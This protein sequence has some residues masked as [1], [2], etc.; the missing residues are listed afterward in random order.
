MPILD[1]SFEEAIAEKK[2]NRWSKWGY[3][4]KTDF[5]D[6]NGE[7]AGQRLWAS[8]I[9]TPKATH[10]KKY[11]RDA[12]FFAVG[13]CFAREIEKALSK[14]GL[15]FISKTNGFDDEEPNPQSGSGAPSSTY[16]T[17][18][19]IFSVLN[20]FRWA[21]EDPAG[22]P[23]SA[24]TEVE[25]GTFVDLHCHTTLRF[26]AKEAALE[27]RR[28]I[29]AYVRQ[30]KG[31]DVIILT[32]GLCELWWDSWEKVYLNVPP[33]GR[34]VKRSPERFRFR[35]PSCIEVLEALR[36]L[37]ELLV[38]HC[39]PGVQILCTVSPVT[40]SDTFTDKDV[41]VANCF[42]KS[43]NRVAVEQWSRENDDVTYF[44]SYEIAL[45]SDPSVA[46]QEDRRHP[47]KE[48]V[49]HIVNTFEQWHLEERED[50]L[51]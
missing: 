11:P 18:Y 43:L 23:E 28:K 21:F 10:T 51:L 45:N 38:K 42:S 14:R 25:S 32:F 30:A 26:L 24:L 29:D 6:V 35:L 5:T 49:A 3:Y 37:R 17:R 13:S 31:A 36:E 41:V 50:E 48:L 8:K 39:K 2:N 1:K 20:G 9:F 16:L 27:R 44:P 46:W 40:L 33:N 15:K 19:S 7:F 22:Y 12:S 4:K 34:M 47:S